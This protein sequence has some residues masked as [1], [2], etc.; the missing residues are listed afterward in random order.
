MGLGLPLALLALLGIGIP[1]WLHRVK[2]KTLRELALPTI[3]L[4]SRA[5]SQRRR[6]LSFRDRPLLYARIALCALFAFALS[7][8][9][10]SQIASYASERPIALAIVLDDSLSMERK[11]RLRGTLFE[12]ARARAKQVLSEL[13]KDSEALVVLAGNEPRLLASRSSDLLSI[14]E[15]LGRVEQVGARGTAL[16][17]AVSLAQRELAGTRLSA[18]EVL[19]LTDCAAHAAADQ[20]SASSGGLRVECFSSRE[21]RGNLYVASMALNRGG[22]LSEPAVL[23]VSLGGQGAPER[24]DVSVRVDGK[25]L[26]ETQ[27]EMEDGTGQA[28]LSLPQPALSRARILELHID[29]PNALRGDDV[30]FLSLDTASEL[31]VLLVDGDPAP[32][33]LDDELRFL[34][35]ALDL[36][37]GERE[38]PHVT[39]IDPDGLSSTDLAPFDVV[40][41]ANVR[42]PDDA[43]AERLRL[44]VARGGGL[45]ITAGDH[46]DAFAYRGRMSEL[47]PAIPRSSAPA[48]PPLSI[49]L[50]NDTSS[51]LLPDM[52]RGLETARITKR[53]LV[54]PPSPPSSALLNYNDGT[55]LLIAGPHNNGRVA[56][57]TTT[58]DDD[59]GDLPLTPGFLPLMHGLVR[60]L[61]AVEALP[62]GP[63][64]AGSVLTAR[65][66]T[67][68][69]SLY[70]V[71][72]DGRRIDV[73]PKRSQVRIEDTAVVGV[74]RAFAAFDERGER[75]VRQLSF[76][77]VADSREND[78]TDRPLTA[79]ASVSKEGGGVARP[80]GIETWFWL[81]LGLAALLE[82]ALRLRRKPE[83]TVAAQAPPT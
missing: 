52:G 6:T 18:K 59:W 67:G 5:V 26:A 78:L 58:V 63:H 82:G 14:K 45:L 51:E 37:D 68:A 16:A 80:R 83:A 32:N 48:D 21:T 55:P 12:A 1:L 30:R 64:A 24:V 79:S 43:T 31:S 46:V 27:V 8:P 28:Q 34:S 47:L 57:L 49:T 70:L 75:E 66:P 44:H 60:G 11:A 50:S 76:T 73:D 20:L 13:A 77:T 7:Q 42:A 53:L 4:L 10:L 41:L 29:T 62:R 19:V 65:V 39:R 38:A 2:R 3:A 25:Q 72:P 40:V 71:T 61:S 35:V 15:E 54:E 33:Q 17:K 36:D 23:N 22:D 69:R 9:F 81:V 56:L 74:Y